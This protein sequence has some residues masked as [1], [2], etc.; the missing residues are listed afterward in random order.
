MMEPG[1]IERTFT[2]S[3]GAV[4]TIVARSPIGTIHIQ[5]EERSDVAV[6]VTCTPADLLGREIEITV[7][8][9]GNTIHAEVRG[10]GSGDSL[11]GWLRGGFHSL[12]ITM[13]IRTP[14]HSN[15][16][17]DGASAERERRALDGSIRVRTASGDIRADRLGHTVNIQSA[18]GDIR[19]HSL[20]GEMRIQ[21]ASGDINLE[22]GEG[23][24][25]IQTA[26]G[27]ATLDQI[28]GTARGDDCER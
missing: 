11:L 24:L 26:S 6:T 2:L 27:D 25:T 10:R 17:A 13:E 15:I 7:E 23:D 28:R 14:I 21:S 19:A 12:R 1:R 20:T 18:S 22:R 4:P 3:P 9:R 16:E 8:E 5:G